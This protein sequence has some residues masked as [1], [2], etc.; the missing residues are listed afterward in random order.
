MRELGDQ[1]IPSAQSAERE[2]AADSL[3]KHDD[4]G[5]NA[6]VLQ[7]EKFSGPAK[8]GQDFIEDEE[9]PGA[10][11][12]VAQGPDEFGAGNSHATLGLHRLDD[13]RRDSRIDRLEPG[14]ITR[15][16]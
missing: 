16:R 12:P 3:R 11:T 6:E 7:R 10:V 1:L 5:G 4:V 14:D 15:G 2:A 13:D 9:C 8:T